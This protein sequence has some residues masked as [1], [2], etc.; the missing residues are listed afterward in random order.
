MHLR[1]MGRIPRPAQNVAPDVKL[2]FIIDVLTVSV[3]LFENKNPQNPEPG[4]TGGNGN[5]ENA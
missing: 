3:P 4:G 5:G 2:T 1:A